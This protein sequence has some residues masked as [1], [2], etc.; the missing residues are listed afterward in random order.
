MGSG[1]FMT[2]AK[3]FG[4]SDIS[5]SNKLENTPK[6]IKLV[7]QQVAADAMRHA[8]AKSSLYSGL[9][10]VIGCYGYSLV[11]VATRYHFYLFYVTQKIG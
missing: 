9:T 11:E 2:T 1:A 7:K 8:S 10:I 6:F 3:N 5:K 4:H